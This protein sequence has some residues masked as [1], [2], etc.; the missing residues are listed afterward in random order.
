VKPS[1]F[2]ILY[3]EDDPN[4]VLLLQRAF[5]KADV[6]CVLQVMA[7]GEQALS[8]LLGQGQYSDRNQFPFPALVLLDLKLPRKAGLEVLAWLRQQPSLKR[9]PVAIL[10]SSRQPVDIALAYDIGVNSYL[11]KPAEFDDLLAMVKALDVYWLRLNEKPEVLP[12]P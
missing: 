7:D 5:R 2:T 4:D 9:L 12:P 8:Y 1:S 6:S 10:T 3:V 11:V